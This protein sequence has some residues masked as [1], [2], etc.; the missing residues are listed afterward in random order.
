MPL[1]PHKAVQS[2]QN[3]LETS[4]M[5]ELRVHHL[6]YLKAALTG[7]NPVIDFT[8]LI[9]FFYYAEFS[10]RTWGPHARLPSYRPASTR[11]RPRGA[12]LIPVHQAP[13]ALTNS[14]QSPTLCQT[15]PSAPCQQRKS[16]RWRGEE[17][18]TKEWN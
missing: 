10:L 14:W 7:L 3:K 18:D 12:M 17:P 9:S 13:L 15:A 4:S 5:R 8:L 6:P 1:Y 16:D 11:V 2:C